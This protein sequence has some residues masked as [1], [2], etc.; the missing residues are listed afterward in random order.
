MTLPFN[1]E[2]STALLGRTPAILHALLA[3]LPAEC[4]E[5]DEARRRS[6][7]GTSS[8]HLLHGERT[9]WM[10]RLRIML[11]H[12]ESRP[13]AP[14][15]RVAHR[16]ASAGLTIVELLDAFGAAR[17]RNLAELE[18]LE[19]DEDAL[20]RTGTHPELGRVTARELLATWVVHDA[21]R[22]RNTCRC[23]GSLVDLRELGVR[24]GG[25][26]VAASRTYPSSSDSAPRTEDFFRYDHQE[27]ST[28]LATRWL[29]T[30]VGYGLNLTALP[31]SVRP[32]AQV[33][34][35]GA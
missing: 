3:A 1:L 32:F 23:C 7:R 12:G 9:D 19:L 14:F 6:A 10:P 30:S 26:Q 25:F 11:E 17:A 34:H 22:G 4:A 8:R 28:D 2:Q 18:T 24:C 33:H 29:I 21:V 13:F 31:V 16:T 5:A 15:D 20:S 35:H 27:E